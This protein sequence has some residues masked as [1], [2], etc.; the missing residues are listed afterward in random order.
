MMPSLEV[1]HPHHNT[2]AP[3]LGRSP[4]PAFR[5]N[6]RLGRRTRIDGQ[7]QK[8]EWPICLV[9]GE[10]PNSGYM[11][12]FTQGHAC[13]RVST[14]PVDMPESCPQTPHVACSTDRAQ[15]LTTADTGS[16]ADD[17]YYLDYLDDL[18]Y[19]Y[20]LYALCALDDLEY[21]EYLCDLDHIDHLDHL[22]TLYDILNRDL[23]EVCNLPSHHQSWGV[24][25]YFPMNEGANGTYQRH[26]SMLSLITPQESILLYFAP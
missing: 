15:H 2:Y 4:R 18:D 20:D 6:T 25:E 17:L 12:R 8:K 7:R 9:V 23:S 13:L 21:L 19:L 1:S 14:K 24:Q 16:T 22:D 5:C 3:E 10:V 11:L 26:I